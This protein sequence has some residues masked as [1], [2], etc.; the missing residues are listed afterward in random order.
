MIHSNPDFE[1]HVADALEHLWESAYLSKHPLASL[2]IVRQRVL[3]DAWASQVEQGRTLS[4]VLR[5]AIEQLKL[6]TAQ[7]ISCPETRYYLILHA[8]Y[9]EG[10]KSNA[11]AHAL[12]IANRTFYT[13]RGQAIR[14]IAQTLREWEE[15]GEA[16]S[17]ETGPGLSHDD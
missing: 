7:R 1:K 17:G 14:V 3:H 15:R 2:R 6:P 8:R 16:L 4:Q 11:I 9:V 10:M 13:S 12:G 5:E